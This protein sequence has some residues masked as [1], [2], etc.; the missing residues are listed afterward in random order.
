MAP[1]FFGR[2][3][4]RAAARW[5]MAAP[6]IRWS[7]QGDVY[8]TRSSFSGTMCFGASGAGKT[9]GPGRMLAHAFLQAGYGACVLTCRPGDTDDW[10]DYAKAAGREGDV[11]LFGPG[12]GHV[13]D[14]LDDELQQAGGDAAMVE[15]IVALLS[16]LGEVGRRGLSGGGQESEPYWRAAGNQLSRNVISLLALAE[17]RVSIPA[18]YKAVTSAPTSFEQLKSEEWRKQSFCYR[19]LQ[20]ADQ[21][22]RTP[23]QD[24][25]FRLVTDYFLQEIPGLSDKTR[26]VILSTLT[27]LIDQLNRGVLRSLFSGRTTTT[28][29]AVEGGAILILD[30]PIKRYGTIGQ[31]GQVLFKQAFMR[32]IERRRI[33]DDTR[34]VALW[35]DEAQFFLAEGEDFLFATTCRGARVANVM[36]TQ[37]LP[38]IVAALGAG[39]QGRAQAAS[40]VANFAT[41][42][43]CA[44]ADAETNQFAAGLIGRSR[45][46]LS[47]GNSS[48]SSQDW[49]DAFLG[50]GGNEQQSGGFQEG[51]EYEFQPHAFSDLR[52]GG[53]DNDWE[54]DAIVFRNGKRFAAGGKSWLKVTFKQDAGK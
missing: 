23:E 33:D 35:A 9:S 2:R 29:R 45:Q 39:E 16:A 15:N 12:H 22:E 1:W 48:R 49:M 37:S 14:V 42:V 17:G 3:R 11:V 24:A 53:P 13:Y 36:L 10:L 51:W 21:K 44:Q 54:I 50:M 30:I 40:L 8:D 7:D 20:Q 52:T 19:M 31:L 47:S 46:Y 6:L 28:P 5:D 34:P 26:S 25:D 32:S 18:I 41:K 4:K 27:S 43:F 38:S